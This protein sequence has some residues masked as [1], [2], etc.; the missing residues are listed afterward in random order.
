MPYTESLYFGGDEEFGARWTRN[1][2]PE[3]YHTNI[4]LEKLTVG[5]RRRMLSNFHFMLIILPHLFLLDKVL[6]R[7]ILF[8]YFNRNARNVS[9]N[10]HHSFAIVIY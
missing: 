10:H 6:F 9:L 2:N 4:K 1:M 5:H 3:K 7:S 8:V